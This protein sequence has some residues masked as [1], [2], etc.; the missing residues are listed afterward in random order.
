[1]E[2]NENEQSLYRERPSIGLEEKIKTLQ[3]LECGTIEKIPLTK[4][5]KEQLLSVEDSLGEKLDTIQKIIPKDT[6]YYLEY[7]LTEEGKKDFVETT[8]INFPENIE[9][10]ED[11]ARFIYNSRDALK[12][13]TPKKRTNLAGRSRNSNED[14]IYKQLQ[15][16]IE[17]GKD[18]GTAEIPSP[19]PTKFLLTPELTLQKI[20]EQRI[21]KQD[22]KA[23]RAEMYTTE[24]EQSPEYRAALLGILDIYQRKINISLSDR[25]SRGVPVAQKAELLGA[26]SLSEEE[27][28]LLENSVGTTRANRHASRYDKFVYGASQ[29]SNNEGMYEQI[30]DE[31]S[32]FADE[33][34]E[35]YLEDYLHRDVNILKKGL[36]PKKIFE[37]NISPEQVEEWAN[38][39][40]SIYDQ[41]EEK[42]EKKWEFES[43]DAYK[44]LSVNG[45]T[46]KIKSGKTTRN[47]ADTLAIVLGHEIEG[48]MV[49]HVN[50]KKI[51]LRLF[52]NLGG[53]RYG[54]N[55]EGGAMFNQNHITEEAFGYSSPPHPH[56]IRAMQCRLNSGTYTECVQAFYESAIKPLQIQHEN[57]QLS[58]DEF[59]EKCKD[60]LKTAVNRT[61]RLFRDSIDNEEKTSYITNSKDT[62]YLEQV[63][64]YK[65]LKKHGLEKYLFISGVN[66]DTAIQL[67]K[68][69]LL[70]SGEIEKPQYHALDIWERVKDSYAIEERH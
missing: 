36:D 46:K 60:E 70:D 29:D 11:V 47:I 52:Q 57:S 18:I 61:K 32:A 15:K 35:E 6:S 56:Y 8:G 28:T 31:L 23:M 27:A 64:L 20:N 21:F 26:D 49:Q 63:K 66:I 10:E 59:T 58:D 62:V 9:T 40:L 2:Q 41:P 39:T 24:N 38:E 33:L 37:K 67:M 50:K 3:S 44:T 68:T 17:E 45:R 54:L 7:F 30:P 22:L 12:E 34:E 14:N 25:L 19:I 13:V 65:E 1:M 42:E 48:H 16:N 51:P 5:E 55:A 69:G 53:D 43:R 4:E